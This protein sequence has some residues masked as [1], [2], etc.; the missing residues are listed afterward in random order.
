MLEE[1]AS[2]GKVVLY[3]TQRLNEAARFNANLFIIKKGRIS[4][5]LR[6]SDLYG[7]ILKGARINIKLAD[8]LTDAVA[9]KVPHFNAALGS[10]IRITVRNYKDINEAIKYR[11]GKGAYIVSVD[12][13][14]PLIEDML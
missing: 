14:E 1:F 6:H 2:D 13:S 8:S 4:K 5:S 3:A 10:N 9:R 12:Y 7:S 11:I